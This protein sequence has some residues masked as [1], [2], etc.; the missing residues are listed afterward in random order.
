MPRTIVPVSSI[1]MCEDPE[2]FDTS[3]F[4]DIG[5]VKRKWNAVILCD[6][7]QSVEVSKE[8]TSEVSNKP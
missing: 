7:D 2:W 8:E 5:I 3:Y 6:A 4:A 1:E